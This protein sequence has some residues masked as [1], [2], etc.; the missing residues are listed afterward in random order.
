MKTTLLPYLNFDGQT[1][2][3]MAFYHSIFGGELSM[4]TYAEA[5]MDDSAEFGG[6]IIHASIRNNDSPLMASDTHPNHSP[7]IVVG[8]NVTLSLIGSDETALKSY[9]ERLSEGGQVIMPLEKQF[10]GDL[11]GALTDKFGIQ[12]MVNIST[13]EH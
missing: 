11:N 7:S 8:N 2:E 5:G 9:F 12:W 10:W 3:A 1:A 4:Q 13:G 6:R